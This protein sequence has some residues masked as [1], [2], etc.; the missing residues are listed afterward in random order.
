MTGI[1]WT[2]RTWNP[3]TGCDKVSPGCKN[4]YAEALAKRLQAMG[5]PRYRNGFDVTLHRDKL[6]EPHGWREGAWVFV[7]SMSDMLHADI[8]DDFL[9]DA[10]RVMKETPRH[11]Y[12]VLTKRPERW[13]SVTAMVVR[14]LGSFPANVLP[15]TSIEN[16]EV[17]DGTRK[18]APRLHALA[19]AGDDDTVRMISGEPL[20]GSLVPEGGTV[21]DLAEELSAARIGWFI[22]GGESAFPSRY[23]A[24]DLRWFEEVRDACA[25][26]GIPYFHKQHGGPGVTKEHKRGGEHATLDGILHHA[27]PTIFGHGAAPSKL[28]LFADKLAAAQDTAQ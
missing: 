14:E 5:N 8:P 25:L 2:D 7:N 12:Q 28:G 1:E 20:L 6:R 9:L 22:T 19:K 21:A 4:C 27:M 16:R 23:R 26:A 18:I 15:G 10:F 11:R 13:E 24:S 17:I 3:A